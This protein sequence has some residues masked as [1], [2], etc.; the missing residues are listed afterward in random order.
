MCSVMKIVFQI[1]TLTHDG[2]KALIFLWNFIISS[3][4]SFHRIERFF[5]ML[6]ACNLCQDLKARLWTFCLAHP[7]EK[8]NKQETKLTN[9]DERKGNLDLK[10]KIRFYL[11]HC[12]AAI[13]DHAALVTLGMC[14]FNV[15]KI[16]VG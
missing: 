5:L 4:H 1:P 9:A 6:S 13:Q 11:V 12:S 16:L 14:L 8:Q 7:Q 15:S 10:G 3:V 2:L